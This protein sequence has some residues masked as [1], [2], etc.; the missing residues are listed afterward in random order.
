MTTLSN[1][2]PQQKQ[3]RPA[4]SKKQ[5]ISALSANKTFNK[6]ALTQKQTKNKK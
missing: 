5:S 2:K 1:K 4:E 6:N 3:A